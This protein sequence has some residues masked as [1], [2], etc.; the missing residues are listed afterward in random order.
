MPQSQP[1]PQQQTLPQK[2][3]SEG[4][5]AW[6]GTRSR[7]TCENRLW[8]KWHDTC[9]LKITLNWKRKKAGITGKLTKISK[10]WKHWRILQRRPSTCLYFTVT[11][12]SWV[13]SVEM[14]DERPSGETVCWGFSVVVAYFPFGISKHKPRSTIWSRASQADFSLAEGGRAS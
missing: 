2:M 5:R 11:L 4:G 12:S 9:A 1:Q 8:E 10:L 14:R 6:C 3:Q 7:V 13:Q